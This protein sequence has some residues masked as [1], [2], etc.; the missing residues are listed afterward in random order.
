MHVPQEKNLNLWLRKWGVVKGGG[1]G[2]FYKSGS[3]DQTLNVY[4]AKWECLFISLPQ[5][6]VPMGSEYRRKEYLNIYDKSSICDQIKTF[7]NIY[8]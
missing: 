3:E 4:T 5:C 7:F 2:I 1:G 8:C 6:G